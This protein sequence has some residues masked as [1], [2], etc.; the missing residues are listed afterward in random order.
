MKL[1]KIL[2]LT[3]VFTMLLSQTAFAASECTLNGETIPCD[4]MPAWFWGVM[5]GMFVFVAFAGVFTLWMLID[6]IR[7]QH[8][9]KFM[10]IAILFFFTFFGA[11]VYY[12]SVKRH[13]NESMT[14]SPSGPTPPPTGPIGV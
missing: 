11:I 1:S 2:S 14:P 8:E 6:V 5:I 9:K 12:F 7:N 4:Q 13:R 10:W 3:S